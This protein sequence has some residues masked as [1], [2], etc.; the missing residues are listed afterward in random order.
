MI[1]Q[2][3]E[4][5]KLIQ[6]VDFSFVYDEL[7]SKYSIDMGRTAVNHIQMFKYLFLK[8]RYNL[9]DR[10]LIEREKTDMA[11]KF[12]IRKVFHWIKS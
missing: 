7:S 11:M 3:H 1:P 12:F 2:D 9:S 10:D 4:L 8:I 5:R 6:L